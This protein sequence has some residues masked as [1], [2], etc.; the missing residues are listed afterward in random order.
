MVNLAE[1]AARLDE[2]EKLLLKYRVLV[3]SD[4]END[5]EIRTDRLL[6]VSAESGVLYV[7]CDGVPVWVALEEAVEVLPTNASE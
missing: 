3:P 5:W 4:G 6:D 7:Q 1:I 2:D